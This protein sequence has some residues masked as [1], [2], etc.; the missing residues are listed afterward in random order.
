MTFGQR[1]KLRRKEL[2]LTLVALASCIGC[3][4]ALVA[5]LESGEKQ[6]TPER[7]EQLADGSG[8][9]LMNSHCSPA[10]CREALPRPSA[11]APAFAWQCYERWT[12]AQPSSI[13]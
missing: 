12:A 9:T 2:G 4:D 5:N 8:S 10:I 7:I 3:S 13:H 11:G 6:P 1:I